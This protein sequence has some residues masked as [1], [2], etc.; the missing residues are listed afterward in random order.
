MD[1]QLKQQIKIKQNQEL[2]G[3]TWKEAGIPTLT[4]LVFRPIKKQT[5]N[6][7]PDDFILDFDQEPLKANG[8]RLDCSC[9]QCIPKP[10][11][12]VSIL[13]LVKIEEGIAPL[14]KKIF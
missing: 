6:H 5:I 8:H 7:Y 9:R 14:N 2:K 4:K 3:I 1:Q 11:S 13:P 12:S 10:K